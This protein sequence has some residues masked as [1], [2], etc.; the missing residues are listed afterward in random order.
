MCLWTS[1][2]W[3]PGNGPNLHRSS[4][5]WAAER[6]TGS[7][8]SIGMKRRYTS[9][10]LA[11][12][13]GPRAGFL[14]RFCLCALRM[15]HLPLPELCFIPSVC[16]RIFFWGLF[17]WFFF[18][19]F[20]N[21][22]Y[23]I[24]FSLRGILH[25]VVRFRIIHACFHSPQSKEISSGIV[26]IWWRRSADPIPNSSEA[27]SPASLESSSSSHVNSPRYSGWRMTRI[28]QHGTAI[29]QM[30]SDQYCGQIRGVVRTW[31]VCASPGWRVER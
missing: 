29:S 28:S 11:P 1:H 5:L 18:S 3:I 16:R 25:K 8:P 7:I 13:I 30:R 15:S 10:H 17:W 21:F 20:F 6:F 22:V 23:V 19:F 14:L 26:R 12:R 4:R 24:F 2:R 9:T 27:I 31:K